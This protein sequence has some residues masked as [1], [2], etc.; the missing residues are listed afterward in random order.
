MLPFHGRICGC[1]DVDVVWGLPRCVWARESTAPAQGKIHVVP[2]SA[3]DEALA[4]YSDSTPR[5]SMAPPS[6]AR[7]GE[8]MRASAKLGPGGTVTRC[9]HPLLHMPAD[10]PLSRM[11]RCGILRP[12]LLEK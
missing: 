8:L 1:P 4:R 6:P 5:P 3:L 11:F 7:M 10:I 2:P 12:R 9:H